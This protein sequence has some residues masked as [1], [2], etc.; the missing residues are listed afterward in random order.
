MWNS[1]K[2]ILA[3][4]LPTLLLGCAMSSSA[5]LP[6]ADRHI[7]RT[8]TVLANTTDADSLAAAGVLN[9]LTHH[10][11]SLSLL[12]QATAAAPTRA[13]LVWLQIQICQAV[14]PCDSEPMERHLRQLDPANGVTWMNALVRAD[15]SKND[16]EKDAAL[17]AISRSDRVDIYWTTLVAHLSRAVAQT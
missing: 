12:Y 1:S 8:A 7:A 10:D 16:A 3:I 6:A 15:L 13:D 17:E 5:R 9:L 11:Q 4:V 2:A 14:L